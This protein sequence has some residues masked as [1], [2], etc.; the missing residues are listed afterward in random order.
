MMA[1]NEI[2]T[3]QDIREIVRIAHEKGAFFHTDA[4]QAFG[5]IPINVRELGVDFLTVSAHKIYGPKEWEPSTCVGACRFCP[6]IHGGHQER[7][8]GPAPKTPSES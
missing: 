2:G 6:L 3:V 8:V 1:N 4:V 7:A 5:K